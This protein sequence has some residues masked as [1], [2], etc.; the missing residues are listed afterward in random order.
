M[1]SVK[2]SVKA[3]WIFSALLLCGEYEGVATQS[4]GNLGELSPCCLQ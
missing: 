2:A 4:T 3:L 1:L